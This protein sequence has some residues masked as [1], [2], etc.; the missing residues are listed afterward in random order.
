MLK[1]IHC[2]YYC[3]TPPPLALST[4]TTKYEQKT[5]GLLWFLFSFSI[6]RGASSVNLFRLFL[7]LLFCDDDFPILGINEHAIACFNIPFDDL[8]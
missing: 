2:H 7:C 3:Q 1:Y 8:H 5:K 4:P 6:Y